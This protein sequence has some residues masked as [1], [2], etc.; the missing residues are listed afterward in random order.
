MKFKVIFDIDTE[1][2]NGSH[3]DGYVFDEDGKNIHELPEKERIALAYHLSR[4]ASN[5]LNNMF[6]EKYK[7]Q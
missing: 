2:E 4:G 1:S 6:Q 5:L 3:A 7:R